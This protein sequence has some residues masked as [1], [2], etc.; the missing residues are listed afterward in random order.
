VKTAGTAK[1]DCG[2]ETN[3]P[4]EWKRPRLSSAGVRQRF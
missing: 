4:T 2:S 1:I 3:R